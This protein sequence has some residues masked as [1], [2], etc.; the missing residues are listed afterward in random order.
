MIDQ[1]DPFD[2]A[3][4]AQLNVF[5]RR[6]LEREEAKAIG[7]K[8][9]KSDREAPRVLEGLEKKQAE[10]TKQWRMYR[11]E[12]RKEY[13]AH[14]RGPYRENFLELRRLLRGLSLHAA[15]TVL[16][17]VER[18]AWLHTADERTR[19]MAL[20]LIAAAIARLRERNGY[21][22]FDDSVYGEEPTVFEIV[23]ERLR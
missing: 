16:E 13:W 6:K 21:P 17:Y 18:A 7:V 14:M 9:V 19:H 20:S 8:L 22:P 23:R 1:A 12:K 11:R 4:R 2:A 3:G 15:D 5:A 10:N